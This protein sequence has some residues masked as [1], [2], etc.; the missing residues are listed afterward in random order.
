MPPEPR[1][2]EPEEPEAAPPGPDGPPSEPEVEPA[3]DDPLRP[4]TIGE[5]PLPAG[6]DPRLLVEFF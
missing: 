5:D 1:P 6:P 3:A 4:H 2:Q